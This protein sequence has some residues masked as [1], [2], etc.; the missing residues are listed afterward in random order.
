M[1][2]STKKDASCMNLMVKFPKNSIALK[3]PT[4]EAVSTIDINFK[5]L[6]TS[7]KSTLKGK[8]AF[9][10][11]FEMFADALEFVEVDRDL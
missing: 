10:L 9:K 7:S 2:F 5:M 3:A 11:A 1:D 8:S 4:M 6:V